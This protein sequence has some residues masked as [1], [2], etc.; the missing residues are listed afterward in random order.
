[1]LPEIG[2]AEAGY[3]PDLSYERWQYAYERQGVALVS[4]DNVADYLQATQKIYDHL[5]KMKKQDATP[6]M[7]W[8]DL[9]LDL[10][11]LFAYRPSDP[12]GLTDLFSRAAYDAYHA[13]HED[14][15]CQQ[16]R[17]T[18]GHLFEPQPEL[19]NYDKECWR[20]QAFEADTNWDS[21]TLQDWAQMLPM[22]VKADF[23]DSL[24]V[25]F[26]RAALR[27]RHLVLEN[28]P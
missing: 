3:F 13:F 1:V 18:F 10:R 7:P 27:Q 24:W 14:I 22:A 5:C 6:R 2:H 9:E 21:Y 11:R 20:K 26:H 15:R 16:W 4:R 19:F 17:E 12:M 25:T 23:W 28:I 8:S